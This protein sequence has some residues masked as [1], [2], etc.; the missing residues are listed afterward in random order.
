M[1]GFLLFRVTDGFGE[2]LLAVAKVL[3][4]LCT[5]NQS[6]VAF[7]MWTWVVSV[8]LDGD[9]AHVSSNDAEEDTSRD[10]S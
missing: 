10:M 4:G 3:R 9:R 5:R 1:E 8:C 7:Y 6:D 2:S